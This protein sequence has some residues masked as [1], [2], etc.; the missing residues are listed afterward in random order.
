MI[1]F[2]YDL[3]DIA[4]RELD[5]RLGTRYQVVVFRIV[6]EKSLHVNLDERET[7]RFAGQT[8]VSHPY[9]TRWWLTSVAGHDFEG[10]ATTRVFLNMEKEQPLHHYSRHPIEVYQHLL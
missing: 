3:K 9:I 5:T 7:I 8:L 1:V 10:D 6:G 2:G 4:H